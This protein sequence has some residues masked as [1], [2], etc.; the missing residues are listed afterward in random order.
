M[1]HELGGSSTSV[2]HGFSGDPLPDPGEP[3]GN[4]FGALPAPET[5][6]PVP[7]VPVALVS[8]V[9]SCER[10]GLRGMFGVVTAAPVCAPALFDDV[11]GEPAPVPAPLPAPAPPPPPCAKATE[12]VR[13]K[14]A[15]T[16]SVTAFEVIA[17]SLL[18]FSK[19]TGRSGNRFPPGRPD[20]AEGA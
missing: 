15:P 20:I 11:P 10:D 12:I 3:M 9:L 7:A 13:A 1:E 2:Y 14:D 18:S 8:R 17:F 6:G 16:R 19:E 4:P 5:D